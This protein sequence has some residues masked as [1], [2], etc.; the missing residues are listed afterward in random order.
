MTD[1]NVNRLEGG[2]I[3]GAGTLNAL[4]NEGLFG[5]GTISTEIEFANNTELRADNGILLVTRAMLDMGVLGTADTDGILNRTVAWNTA[6][7]IEFVNM[8][9]GEIR[10]GTITNDNADGIFGF[11]L[12]SAGHQQYPTCR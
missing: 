5:F 3:N 6:T 10:G 7:N 2:T 11:G 8:R 9:G 1:A 4:T 12:I